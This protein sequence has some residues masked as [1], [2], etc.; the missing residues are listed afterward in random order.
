[1]LRS[2]IAG[3]LTTAALAVT[4]SAAVA[5]LQLLPV[6]G[7]A[8]AGA[9]DFDCV[10]R[11]DRP[12]VILVHGALLDMTSSWTVLAPMLLR[13]GF[14]LFAVDYGRRGTA[15]VD[16]SA[17]ELAAFT[18]RVL[19]QTGAPRVSF[20]G[21]GQGGL[22]ARWTVK[23]RGLLDSTEEIVGLAPSHHGTTSQA[24]PV[25]ASF[26]CP[27][28][29]DQTAGSAF[30]ALVNSQPEAPPVIDHTVIT[31]LH[32]E[33]VT[34]PRSQALD[35]ETVGNVVLQDQCP[36]DLVEHAGII[37]DPIALQWVRHALLRDGPADPA[38]RADCDGSSLP[39][40]P[41]GGASRPSSSA[42]SP[43]PPTTVRLQ[44]TSTS[45]RASTRGHVRLRVRCTGPQDGRCRSVLRL[46]HGDRV[47]GTLRATLPAGRT[48]TVTLVLTRAGRRL[49]AAHRHGIRVSLRVSTD[50]AEPRVTA[51]TLTLRPG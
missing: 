31:T 23:S 30:L 1:M 38:A 10:P 46:R 44:L 34:P 4:A 51:R 43:P 24:A 45:L 36:D 14:C 9:N 50:G 18:H 40:E 39:R 47:L 15:P 35:G 11:A 41:P 27:A 5:Q 20:V 12:P 48:A 42:P 7:I 2:G 25:V 32:D 26:G 37:F 49:V 28:C 13:D 8:P 16:A 19:E 3:I 21:H 29:A 17:D 22:L 6:P 33:I